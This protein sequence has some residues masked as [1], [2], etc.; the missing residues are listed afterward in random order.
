MRRIT[1]RSVPRAALALALAL[2]A[3][4]ALAQSG[5]ARSLTA[6]GQTKPP[7]AVAG[8]PM[9]P[10]NEAAMLK[11]QQAAEA[12]NKAWDSKMRSTL[13]SICRGC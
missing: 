7:G 10:I 13:G 1:C 5:T 3:A 12:R 6:T 4:P 11:A 9:K 8:A 2:G